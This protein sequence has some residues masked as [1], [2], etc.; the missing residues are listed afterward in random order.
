MAR[1]ETESAIEK[2]VMGVCEGSVCVSVKGWGGGWG[3]GGGG[4]GS[5][6]EMDSL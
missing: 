1:T 2:K 6:A 3:D 5:E 4:N